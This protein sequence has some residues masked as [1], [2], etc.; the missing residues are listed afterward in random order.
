[1]FAET[2][3]LVQSC[4]VPEFCT[5]PSLHTLP[6]SVPVFPSCGQVG[7]LILSIFPVRLPVLAVPVAMR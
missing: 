5:A 6:C 2:V 7:R 4:S 3:Q 1:M